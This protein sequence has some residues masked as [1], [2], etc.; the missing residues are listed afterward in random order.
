[1]SKHELLAVEVTHTHKAAVRIDRSLELGMTAAHRTNVHRSWSLSDGLLNR[2]KLV[3]NRLC[4]P[5]AVGF[6]GTLGCET[7][8]CE[9]LF[10][11]LRRS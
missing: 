10:E 2:K 9:T 5:T 4:R 11:I 6:I 7:L 1:M 8:G 3:A